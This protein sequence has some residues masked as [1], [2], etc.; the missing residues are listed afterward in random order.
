MPQPT[1]ADLIKKKGAWLDEDRTGSLRLARKHSAASVAI[2]NQYRAFE[3]IRTRLFKGT[4]RHSDLNPTEACIVE[5]LMDADLIRE[6]PDG[7]LRADSAGS[8]RY[9]TGGWLEEVA[10][11]AALEAGA[12]EALYGQSVSWRVDG[13]YG[14]NEIDVIA[15]YGSRLAFYSCKAFGASY[16][17]SNDRR[18]KKLM[19]ALHEA[20]NMA[21]HFGSENAFVGLILS[22]DLYDHYNRK[23]KYEALFGK[24]RALNVQLITLD[25][26]KWH[27][28]VNAMG[29]ATE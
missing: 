20:D 5:A 16:R 28:L 6:M 11:L 12:D 26:L 18:R 19:E 10:C 4:I 29:K 3:R 14:E 13:Y 1:I 27:N 7:G 15:R 2:A 21:D 22:T 24:A 17:K 8:R 23:P 25:D 9:I